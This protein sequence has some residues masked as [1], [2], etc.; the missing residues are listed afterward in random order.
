MAQ[1]E[2]ADEDT[3]SEKSS[4]LQP[5][6]RVEIRQAQRSP[7]SG[8]QFALWLALLVTLGLLTVNVGLI[9]RSLRLQRASSREHA[10]WV[11]CQPG[12]SATARE[13]AFRQLVAEGNKEWRSA[14]LHELNLAGISLPGADLQGA[15]F[16]RS[17]LGGANLARARFCNGSLEQ[18]DLSGAD[19]SQAD[20]SETQMLRAILKK[21]NLHRAK[22]RATSIEQ[23]QAEGADLM[24]ADLSD[25]NCLMANLAGAKLDGANLSGAR[26]DAA[27]LK[28]ASLSLT[29]FDG[30][31]LKNAE[32]TNANWW[33]ARGLRPGQIEFLK[34]QFAPTAAADP[35][36]KQDYAKW[37][38][39]AGRN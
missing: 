38:G 18:A 35:A 33:R 1:I 36:L 30:A 19:L 37:L 8:M 28:G 25:A 11:L 17:S 22:M 3:M 24:L 13:R 29:R 16:V 20:L 34:Q 15:L 32:F 31:D 27:V 6:D 14:D 2:S 4:P 23:V 10:F 39:D 9:S 21:T 5:D 26:L 12:A 7:M